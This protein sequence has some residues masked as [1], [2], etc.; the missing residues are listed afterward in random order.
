V[1]GAE[2]AAKLRGFDYVYLDSQKAAWIDRFQR[3]VAR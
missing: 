2:A 3:E 1:F